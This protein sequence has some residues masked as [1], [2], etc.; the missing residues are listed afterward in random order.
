MGQPAARVSDMHTCPMQ[1]PI[2]FG[3]IPHVGGPIL[4]PGV[5]VVLIGGLPAAVLS[6]MC[7]CVG[8]P[9]VIIKG[10][11]GVFFGGLPAAR[12]GDNTAHGGVIVGGFP[13]VLIGDIGGGGSMSSFGDFP[14]TIEPQTL[15]E[16]LAGVP[17]VIKYGEIRIVGDPS[18][19]SFQGK[20]LQDLITLNSTPTG[21]N[22]LQS[23]NDSGKKVSIEH[24]TGG[25]GCSYRTSAQR[26]ADGTA[27]TPSDANVTYNP[28]RTKI[29]DETWGTRPPAIGLGHELIHADHATHGQ[30]YT[31]TDANDSKPNPSSTTTPPQEDLE[32]LKTAGIPPHDTDDF[33]ENKLRTE[34][35]PPQPQRTWY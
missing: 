22:V 15:A 1:T 19:P 35:N 23:L 28:D 17:P 34:W 2:L 24:T 5:P 14:I 29:N 12:M 33:N 32:E 27:G 3:T 18:D 21:H 8:P 31:G 4:P 26:N 11:M 6:N 16:M 9:D 10:S 20:T 7:I 30:A 13:T 25:N